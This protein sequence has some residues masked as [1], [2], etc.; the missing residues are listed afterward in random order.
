LV[1]KRAF[2]N[3]I[4]NAV[5]YGGS[6]SVTVQDSVDEIKVTV[7]DNGPGIRPDER[8]AMFAPFFRGEPH[9]DTK[10]GGAGLGLTIARTIIR[11][12]GGDLTLLDA[13]G[14]GLKVEVRLPTRTPEL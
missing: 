11:A 1:L 2:A 9:R 6:A 10:V 14:G 12:H 8:E 4:W 13:E 5:T 3:L 7:V